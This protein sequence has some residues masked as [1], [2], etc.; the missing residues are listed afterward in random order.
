MNCSKRL[1]SSGG[2]IGINGHP[3]IC[4]WHRLDRQPTFEDYIDVIEYTIDLVGID[5]WA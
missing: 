3:A 2:V 4:A 1:R 5:M